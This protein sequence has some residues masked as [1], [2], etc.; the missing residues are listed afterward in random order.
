MLDARTPGTT[1]PHSQNKSHKLYL[2]LET[3]SNGRPHVV[4]RNSDVSLHTHAKRENHLTLLDPVFSGEHSVDLTDGMWPNLLQCPHFNQP[5][6]SSRTPVRWWRSLSRRWGCRR[7]DGSRC[8]AYWSRGWDS[9]WGLWSPRAWNGVN[10]ASLTPCYTHSLCTC[11]CRRTAL[12]LLNTEGLN[13][14]PLLMA[15]AC[16]ARTNA[17]IRTCGVRARAQNLVSWHWAA[18]WPGWGCWRGGRSKTW[19]KPK[20]PKELGCPKHPRQRKWWRHLE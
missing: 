2:G 13:I 10:W 11:T 14:W 1:T 15:F 12:L 7:T 9:W 4:N 6:S 20:H 16:L 18:A 17:A 8:A 3:P 19:H 5:T